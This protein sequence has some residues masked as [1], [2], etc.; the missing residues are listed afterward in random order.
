M[1]Y[2][3]SINCLLNGSM[4]YTYLFNIPCIAVAEEVSLTG[5][6]VIQRIRLADEAENPSSNG[7]LLD[8]DLI[9]YYQLQA[10]N[11]DVQAQVVNTH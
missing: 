5:G 9:Q 2:P 6:A 3:S 11:G 4:K 1:N 10:K 8:E 7:G